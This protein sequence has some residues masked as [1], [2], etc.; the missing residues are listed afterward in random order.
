M[1]E[2][3]AARVTKPAYNRQQLLKNLENS[4][5]AR[6][7]S[8]FDDYLRREYQLKGRYFAERITMP[9]GKY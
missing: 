3:I 7:S 9:D 4:R 5:L 2:P 8:R 1:N 6:K